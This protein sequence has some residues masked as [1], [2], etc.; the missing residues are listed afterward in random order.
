LICNF[1]ECDQKMKMIKLLYMN[2]ILT[3]GSLVE[4][5]RSFICLINIFGLIYFNTFDHLSN[6]EENFVDDK[7]YQN[8]A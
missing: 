6:Y 2:H 3:E 8:N 7:N 5:K 1:K 4:I